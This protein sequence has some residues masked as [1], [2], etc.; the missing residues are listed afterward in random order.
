[1]NIADLQMSEMYTLSQNKKNYELVKKLVEQEKPDLLTFTGDNFWLN[2]AKNATKRFVKNIDALGVP[3][4][5]VFGNHEPETE[6]DK[7][8]IM[9]EFLKA[10]NCIF[11]YGDNKTRNKDLAKGPNNI[12]GVGNYVINVVN[13]DNKI[14]HTIFMM[15]SHSNNGKDRKSVV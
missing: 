10:E 14:I 11:N 4:A 15:D 12:D 3:W 13:S 6:V 2:N 5:P 1:M 9:D 7:N 8:W